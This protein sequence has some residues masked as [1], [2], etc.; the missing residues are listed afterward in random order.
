VITLQ[1]KEYKK[2]LDPSII[3]RVSSLELRARMIV[4]G[5]LVGL[6]KSPYHGFSAEFSQHRP[7]IQGDPLRDID[8]KIYAKSDKYYIKQYEEET[9]LICNIFLDTSNSMSFK[10]SSGVSKLD[11]GITLAA[12]LSYLLMNQKDAVGLALYSDKINSYLP[13]RAS[14]VYLQTILT[15][16]SNTEAKGN[17]SILNCLNLIAEKIKKRGLTIFISDFMEDAGA[18]IKTL[19]H[20]HFK[21]NEVIVFHLLDPAEVNFNFE[22]DSTFVD[23]E[24]GEEIITQPHLIKKAYR[25]KMKEHLDYLKKE[26][27]NHGIEYNLIDTSQSFEKAL[28]NYYMKRAKMF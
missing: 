2:Y 22:S 28:T 7:Y 8:W 3:S 9:N 13:P 14:K 23:L 25:E 20:L 15:A 21:K 12:G 5:F 4:E 27:R 17:T 6:H 18:V 24:T 1:E 26:C 10:Y 19:K 16:L 11:Y